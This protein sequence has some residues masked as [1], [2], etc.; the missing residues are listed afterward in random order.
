MLTLRYSDEWSGASCAQIGGHVA[1]QLFFPSGPDQHAD[2]V[3]ICAQCP[4]RNH[5]LERALEE[6]GDRRAVDRFGIRGGLNPTQ[7]VQLIHDRQFTEGAVS[8]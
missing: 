1:D 8:A 7:R 4:L 2:G 6:E 3:A 5:C